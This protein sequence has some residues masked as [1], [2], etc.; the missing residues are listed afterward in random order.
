MTSA[1]RGHLVFACGSSLYA[2]PADRASEVVN[3]PVLTRVPGAP[4]HLLGVFAHRGEVVPVVD[5][6]R[7][8]AGNLEVPATTH[9]RAVLVRGGKG[10]V[11]LTASKVHGVA[12]LGGTPKRLADEGVQ[13]HFSGPATAP[14][15]DAAILDPD[16]LVEF[17]SKGA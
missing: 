1:S 2:L 12:T 11:A 9:R 4:V 16:G 7:L 8:L 14:A 6:P 15:G 10:V 17:L 13:A 5:L 3:L